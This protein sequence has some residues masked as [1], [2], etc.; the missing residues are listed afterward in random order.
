M[1][2]STPQQATVIVDTAEKIASVLSSLTDLPASPPSLYIDL[3][4]IDLGRKGTISILSIHVLPKLT[5]Y[6]IDIQTLQDSAFITPAPNKISTNLKSILESPTIPKVLFDVRNDSD[7]LFALYGI[8]LDGV[9][10]LQLMELASRAY[11]RNF[12]AGL[13]KSIEKDGPFSF[14]A[15]Q[16]WKERK[17][18]FATGD[19]YHR[20][21]IRPFSPKA[22]EYCAQ[23]V[24]FLPGLWNVY[25]AKLVSDQQTFWRMMIR[26]GLKKRL[27]LSRSAGYN[28]QG[29]DKA[30]GPWD[31][32]LVKMEE[33]VWNDGVM[34]AAMDGEEFPDSPILL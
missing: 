19:Q 28:P 29:P 20:L 16:S 8:S 9:K 4:G 26:E 11:S 30:R 2:T 10:D 13:A 6:L 3:E 18:S 14:Q 33:D 5:T 21:S 27:A 1:S 24:T 7:A 15:K 17:L 22:I 32:D 23:D 31:E 12:L 34:E 25:A